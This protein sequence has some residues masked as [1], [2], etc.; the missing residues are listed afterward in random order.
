VV[1]GLDAELVRRGVVL[2]LTNLNARPLDMLRRHPDAA[3]WAPR[4]F[5]EPD[6]AATAFSAR[7]PRGSR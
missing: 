5:R 1:A 6:E 7:P 4:L 2:W 3:A